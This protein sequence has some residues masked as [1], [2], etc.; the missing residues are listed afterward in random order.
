MMKNY[1]V[2]LKTDLRSSVY[3]TLY[4]KAYSVGQLV[5]Q[6]GEDYYVT[7]IE[8]WKVDATRRDGSRKEPQDDTCTG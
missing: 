3:K 6:L 8:E 7:E 2:K 1:E 5:D 4:I